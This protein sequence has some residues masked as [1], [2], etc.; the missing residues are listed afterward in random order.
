MNFTCSICGGEHSLDE[1]SFG[2]NAPLQWRLLSDAERSQSFL[3]DE[4]CEIES[5]EGRSFYIRACLVLPIQ[6]SSRTF[7]WG[8]WC[9]LSEASYTEMAQ[10]WED[11]ARTKR[12][13]YFGWLCTSIPGYPE[14]A[15]LKSLVHQREVGLRPLVELEATDH[16][17]ALDQKN[18]IQESRLREIVNKL[19]HN[20]DQ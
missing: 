12:G 10:Y 2:S 6:E 14:T 17:L 9:S 18:G 15:F 3:S 20:G 7:T 8:V 1:V 19:I 4:Q 13:P 11:P 16:P 5:H